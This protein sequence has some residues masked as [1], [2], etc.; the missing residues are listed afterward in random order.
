M[1]RDLGGQVGPQ[2]AIAGDVELHVETFA[3][4]AR[5]CADRQCHPLPAQQA[6]G[7]QQPKPARAQGGFV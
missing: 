6:A 3:H 2:G 7:K 4:Q 5:R 1:A